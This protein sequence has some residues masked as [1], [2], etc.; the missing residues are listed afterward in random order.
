MDT[1]RE[2]T[3]RLT[4]AMVGTRH[5]GKLPYGNQI[6]MVTTRAHQSLNYR[7][8][9]RDSTR[10]ANSS[11]SGRRQRSR[12]SRVLRTK[13]EGSALISEVGG[14]MARRREA[15]TCSYHGVSLD[16]GD[17]QGL[18]RVGSRAAARRRARTTVPSI[19]AEGWISIPSLDSSCDEHLCLRVRVIVGTARRSSTAT[20]ISTSVH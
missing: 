2:T 11:T 5:M 18:A 10:T 4:L 7:T 15:R 20:A 16:L 14:G 3:Q 12:G 9:G 19:A 17:D 1:R 13:P 6:S 8:S